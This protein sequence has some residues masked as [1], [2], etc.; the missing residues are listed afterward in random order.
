MEPEYSLSALEAQITQ[1]YKNASI[2]EER[3]QEERKKAR[4]MEQL[5]DRLRKERAEL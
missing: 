2:L 5:L 1:H 3:A 4:S